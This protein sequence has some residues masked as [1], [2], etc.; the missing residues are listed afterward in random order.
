M[1]NNPDFYVESLLNIL[2]KN[3]FIFINFYMGIK[4][5][6]NLR[7]PFMIHG[8]ILNLQLFLMLRKTNVCFQFIYVFVVRCER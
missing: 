6:S 7:V 5:D 2:N 8:I 3:S 1:A 4:S